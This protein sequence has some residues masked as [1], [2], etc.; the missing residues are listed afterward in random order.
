MKVKLQWNNPNI[1]VTEVRVY[2]STSTMNPLSLP[3]ALATLSASA[4]EYEDTTVA[5]DTQYYY[6]IGMTVSG[7][8][9]VSEEYTV[10]TD[11]YLAVNTGMWMCA[12]AG[13]DETWIRTFNYA[14]TG[15]KSY[16]DYFEKTSLFGVFSYN[17]VASG[18]ANTGAFGGTIN[19]FQPGFEFEVY[20]GTGGASTYYADF[21]LELQDSGGTPVAAIRCQRT[22]SDG[23]VSVWYGSSLTNLQEASYYTSTGGAQRKFVGKL[24]FQ[25][26]KMSFTLDADFLDADEFDGVISWSYETDLSTVTK[27]VFTNCRAQASTNAESLAYLKLLPVAVFIDLSVQINLS[28]SEAVL[29]WNELTTAVDQVAIYR[30]TS[31]LDTNSLPTA[32]TTVAAGTET[33]TDSSV[34]NTT[35]YFYMIDVQVAGESNYS[36]NLQGLFVTFEYGREAQYEFENTTGAV[37]TDETTSHDAALSGTYSVI[38]GIDGNA[39]NFGALGYADT[40]IDAELYNCEMIAG[41]EFSICGWMRRNGTNTNDGAVCGRGGGTG[42]SATY[43]VFYAGSSGASGQTQDNLHLVVKGSYTD[44]GID[45]TDNEWHFFLTTWDGYNGVF[46]VDDTEVAVNVGSVALQVGNTFAIAAHGGGSTPQST[47][48]GLCDIDKMRCFTRSL[49]LKERKE[50][51]NEFNRFYDF[52][53]FNDWQNSEVDLSWTE[54]DPSEVTNVVIYRDTSAI[55]TGSLPTA[56]ATISGGLGTYTDTTVVS[57]T[58]YFYLIDVQT[59]GPVSHYSKNVTLTAGIPVSTGLVFYYDFEAASGTNVPDVLGTYDGTINGSAVLTPTGGYNGTQGF[60]LDPDENGYVDIPYTGVGGTGAR[61]MCAW[62]KVTGAFGTE[63]NRILSY[64]E[65]T[66]GNKW[67]TRIDNTSGHRL[68]VE[69]KGGNKVVGSASVLN[70]GNWHHVA[71]V[72]PSGETNVTAHEMYVDG[73]LQSTYTSTSSTINTLTTNNLRIGATQVSN[74]DVDGIPGI[75]DNVRFYNRGLSAAEVLEIYNSGT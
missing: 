67:H 8:D 50:L 42:S 71:V 40:S 69:T 30:D 58:T 1:R 3:A 59:T 19:D 54:I 16:E 44:S 31:P 4:L 52:S 65:N 74:E 11:A 20:A 2:R 28:S 56:L 63:T 14:D 9:V 72:F 6:R 53:A 32:L 48:H 25:T 57:G 70:D 34:S 47:L 66:T 75:V 73:V 26:G 18:T 39:V 15:F 37:L 12:A 22:E 61:S 10:F 62:I 27:M 7:T 5:A 38:T 45:V 29:S 23:G 35:N 60:N 51:A 17:Y 36:L 24:K 46:R 21:E 49:S 13:S 33:Y 43:G 41:N 68:R 55:D 64:G